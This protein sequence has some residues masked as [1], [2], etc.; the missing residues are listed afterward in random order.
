MTE[1]GDFVFVGNSDGVWSEASAGGE[2]FT[3]VKL[4]ADGNEVTRW[5]VWESCARV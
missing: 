1:D 3:A 2:D 5:Q 4:D